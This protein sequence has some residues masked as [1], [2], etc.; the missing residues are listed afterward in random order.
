MI[1]VQNSEGSLISETNYY[2]QV[3]SRT[4]EHF[5]EIRTVRYI[6]SQLGPWP[7]VWNWLLTL[8]FQLLVSLF[9]EVLLSQSFETNN[10]TVDG[11]NTCL[12]Y[13]K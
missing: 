5:I 10:G 12:Q 2:L 7:T 4:K 1:K 8:S 11:Y 9:M 6:I 3:T 13:A